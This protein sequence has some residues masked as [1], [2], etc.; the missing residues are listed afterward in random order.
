[1][2]DFLQFG[3]IT[4]LHDLGTVQRERL[5]A[6]LTK[7]TAATKLGLVL[8][9]TASDMRAAPFGEDRPAANGSGLHSHD[10]CGF[11]CRART[12]PIIWN[13]DRK[14]RRWA[15][16]HM[17]SGPMVPVFKR[18]TRNSSIRGSTCAFQEKADPLGLPLAFS[19][20]TLS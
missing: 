15:L 3:T 20:L 11:G 6:L 9:V 14:H 12:N 10:R 7:A 19:W 17:C 4:T 18:S 2:A 1:M 5:E 8:P 13:A 16:R